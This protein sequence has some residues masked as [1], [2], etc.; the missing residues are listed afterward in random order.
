MLNAARLPAGILDKIAVGEAVL[1]R[2]GLKL[3]KPFLDAA[4]KNNIYPLGISLVPIVKG[5][6]A[7][8]LVEDPN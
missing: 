8:G 5:M 7:S 1:Q 6:I 2:L 3:P 4:R